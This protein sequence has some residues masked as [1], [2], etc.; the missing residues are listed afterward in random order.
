MSTTTA[1]Y[2]LRAATRIAA[3]SFW[4]TASAS[5]G[6]FGAGRMSSPVRGSV[7]TNARS[8]ATSTSPAAVARSAMVARGATR[9]RERRVAELEVQ[10]D[11]HACGGPSAPRR[12]RGWSRRRSCRSRPWARRRSRPCRARWARSPSR[13]CGSRTGGSR[14]AAEARRR[15]S[16]RSRAR[17]RRCRSARRRRRGS[18]GR[19]RARG[20][21]PPPRRC[22]APRRFRLR[23]ARRRL[24]EGN[25]RPPH[26][27]GR[28][29]SPGLVR[30][31]WRRRGRQGRSRGRG[32]W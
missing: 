12:P 9:H 7:L 8:F 20:R 32:G 2:A 26:R 31:S 15:R 17:S 30:A 16:R 29:R 27:R 28:G 18:A 24:I 1:S 10:V 25:P 14:P 4:P 13:P 22:W 21:A 5:S 19:R 6:R 3:S 11:E 23:G